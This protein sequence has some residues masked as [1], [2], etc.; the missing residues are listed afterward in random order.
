MAHVSP[1]DSC[2]T[3]AA[4]NAASTPKRVLAATIAAATSELNFTGPPHNARN[5]TSISSEAHS[6]TGP[7]GDGP[8]PARTTRSPPAARPCKTTRAQAEFAKGSSSTS[9]RHQDDVH[10]R[11]FL[12]PAILLWASN[13]ARP[14]F[15]VVSCTAILSLAATACLLDALCV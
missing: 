7:S 8:G 1:D 6:G 10:F 9:N 4:R 12:T 2:M 13:F 3:I 15:V 14:A 5:A 11:A